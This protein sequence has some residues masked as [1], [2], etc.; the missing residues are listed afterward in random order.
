MVYE[1]PAG[2]SATVI[3][4]VR[5]RF[6]MEVLDTILYKNYSHIAFLVKEKP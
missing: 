4:N 1:V 6:P 2:T 3:D 5:D